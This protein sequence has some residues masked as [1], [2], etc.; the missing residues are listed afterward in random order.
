MKHIR[1]I[2][3]R[4]LALAAVI[5]LTGCDVHEFP[6]GVEPPEPPQKVR[7]VKL[8][9]EFRHEMPVYQTI[10]YDGQMRRMDTRNAGE[11]EL[12][13]RYIVRAYP[14]STEIS[15]VDT[16]A[17]AGSWTFYRSMQLDADTTLEIDCPVGDYRFLVWSDLV[18][19]GSHADY[20]YN[21]TTFDEI[22]LTDR[23]AHAGSTDSRDAH[24]GDVLIASSD[25]VALVEMVRPLAKY[26]F[27][28]TDL[29]VFIRKALDALEKENR[30]DPELPGADNIDL[31]RYRIRFTYPRYMP[32]SFNMFLNRPA[33]SWSNVTFDSSIHR[34][35]EKEAEIGFD[36]IFVNTHDTSV[37]VYVEVYDRET[38]QVLGRI[39]P[40]DVPLSRSR[41]TIVKGPF[42]TTKAQG[43]TGIDPIT[44]ATSTYSSSKH[45]ILK[46]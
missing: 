10:E 13:R 45:I 43:G 12:E 32:C 16:R 5:L 46:I 28:T 34:I 8:H 36:Y 7:K 24:R 38:G 14:A 2:A 18:V 35:N 31:G 41:L 9:L 25:S 1:K 3:G 37:N 29:D 30:T 6:D 4:I 20:Y 26:Q 19:A 11:P 22:K 17:E 27:V 15:G 39:S 21:T 23:N 33:D 40:I 44:T 42:L